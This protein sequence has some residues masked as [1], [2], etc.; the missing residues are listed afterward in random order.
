[1]SANTATVRE[2]RIDFRAVKRKLEQ[3]GEIV[4]TDRGEPAYVLKPFPQKIAQRAA[5]PDYYA[6][7]MQRQP[8]ALSAEETRQFW[9]EERR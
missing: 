5:L 8:K 9:E 3:H 7:V 4:I 1:V 2:L 6:R